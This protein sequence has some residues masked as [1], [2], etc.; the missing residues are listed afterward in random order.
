[1]TDVSCRARRR[2]RQHRDPRSREDRHGNAPRRFGSRYRRV[3]PRGRDGSAVGCPALA[4][5]RLE[6][7]RHALHGRGLLGLLDPAAVQQSARAGD[8]PLGQPR[9]RSGRGRRSRHLRGRRRSRRIDQ[10]DLER[11]DELLGPRPGPL[12]RRASGRHRSRGERD[13]RH[14]E[15]AAGDGVRS[16]VLLVHRGGHADHA[17][18]RRAPEEPVPD[19]A[20]LRRATRAARCSRAPTSSCRC[21]TRWTVAPATPRARA[22]AAKPAAGWIC[23]C[24]AER[25]YA[26]HPAS[27]RREA[28]VRPRVRVRARGGGLRGC[29]ALRDRPREGRPS[30]ARAAMPRTRCLGS[31]IRRGSSR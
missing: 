17:V 9:D 19:D 7:P 10:H 14:R 15:R 22:D 28:G 13:A 27:A 25:D 18:R 6:Q 20:P 3:S 5:R 26:Q 16:D 21:P 11:Q 4:R 8:R 31:G 2:T 30:S 24:R 23:D 29:R 12:R 1:M